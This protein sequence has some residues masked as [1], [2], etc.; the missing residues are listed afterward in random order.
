MLL[1][2]ALDAGATGDGHGMDALSV[3]WLGHKPIAFSE[4]AGSGRAFFGFARAAID[5]A[6][7]YAA[8]DADVTLRLWRALKPRLVAEGM[9][10]STRL[11]ASAGRVS[12]AHGASRNRHQGSTEPG[13]AVD[14]AIHTEPAVRRLLLAAFKP[15]RSKAPSHPGAQGERC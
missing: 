11:G 1:S 5:K 12:C 2:Y 4:I 7:E 8:E 9:R 10:R 13:R 3:Q 14:L 15:P 6:S